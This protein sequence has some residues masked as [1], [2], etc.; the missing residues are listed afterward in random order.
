MKMLARHLLLAALLL[1]AMVPLGW[2]PGTAQLG[3][4]AWI[5]CTA[6]GDIQH[7]APGKD[8]SHQQHQQPCAFGAAHAMASPQTA[9]FAAP[10]LQRV[11]FETSAAPAAIRIAAPFT[12]QA[13]RAPPLS[14]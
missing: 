6:A 2:M 8:D 10:L 14:A 11:A 7:G 12:P 5:I 4:A 3:Q 13:P 1:R 9:S